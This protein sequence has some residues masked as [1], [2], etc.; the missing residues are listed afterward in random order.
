MAIGTLGEG[1]FISLLEGH[2]RP[3]RPIDTTELLF[4]REAAM[5]RMQEAF[6]SMG[7]GASADI[8]LVMR[9]FRSSRPLL[10]ECRRPFVLPRPAAASTATSKRELW[11]ANARCQLNSGNC[12]GRIRER[13][14]PSH[15]CATPLDRAVVLLDQVVEVLVRA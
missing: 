3:S 15:R 2:L 6:S 9:D 10:C 5:E 12:D 4:G 1:E 13:F 11:L 14:E 8:L 7:C